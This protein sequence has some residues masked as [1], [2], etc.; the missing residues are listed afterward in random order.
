MKNKDHK[1]GFT[2]ME[3]LIAITV[4]TL[5]IF[6]ATN[7]V[8]SIMRSNTGNINTLVGYG[9]AQ[10]GLEAVR[11]IRDSNWLLG[12]DFDGVHKSSSKGNSPVWGDDAIFDGYYTVNINTFNTANSVGHPSELRTVAPWAL[13]KIK[14]SQALDRS[15]NETQIYKFVDNNSGEVVFKHR[16]FGRS[17]L[18]DQNETGFHR[19]IKIDNL[20]EDPNKFENM[21]VTSVVLWDE[22]GRDSEIRLV[23]ELTDWNTGQL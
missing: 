11:N 21:R 3:V 17:A 12:V 20:S 18:N 22:A 7:L 14:E 19:Y 10:E 1:K 8:V 6:T 2:I 23:S 13:E 15:G 9:L 5:V 4:I 16:K